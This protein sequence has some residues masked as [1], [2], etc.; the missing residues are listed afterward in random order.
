M[1]AEKSL[2]R[3]AADRIGIFPALHSFSKR[4]LNIDRKTD[5]SQIGSKTRR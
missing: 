5:L 4:P 2:V 1:T 3:W